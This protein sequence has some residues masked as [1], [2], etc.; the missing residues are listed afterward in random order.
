MEF[1]ANINRI[2]GALAL[3]MTLDEIVAHFDGLPMDLL[4]LYYQA[5]RILED[6]GQEH[7]VNV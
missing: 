6:D 7:N 5:A 4:F 2:R 3:G 1:E